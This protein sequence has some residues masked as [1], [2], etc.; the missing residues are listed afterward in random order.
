MAALT[1]W[2]EIVRML[3]SK[4]LR[5]PNMV[6]VVREVATELAKA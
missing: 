5:V 1:D 3:F 2:D 6:H 4:A